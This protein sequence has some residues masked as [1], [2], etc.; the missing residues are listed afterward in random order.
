MTEPPAAPMQGSP[1]RRLTRSADSRVGGVAGGFAEYFEVDPTLARL[2]AVV[3]LLVS[4]GSV[5][6]AYVVLW[7]VLPSADG[8]AA[9]DQF[10]ARHEMPSGLSNPQWA[11]VDRNKWVIGAIVAVLIFS[12]VILDDW[13]FGSVS[14]GGAFLP[15]L[16]IGVGVLLMTRRGGPPAATTSADP[17]ARPPP[18][19]VASPSED[20]PPPPSFS[21]DGGAPLV[22][23]ERPTGGV[24]PPAPA[25]A[26]PKP[27]GV[28]TPVVLS[29][30][31]A[32]AG[33][34]LLLDQTQIIDASL[35]LGGAVWLFLIGA[36]LVVSA[37][38]GRAP[39]L[40]FIGVLVAIGTLAAGIVDPIIEHGS[41][42]RRIVVTDI[43]DLE[44]EYQLGAGSLTV[45]LS[46]LDLN[47][48]TRTVDVGLA[49][50][51]LRVY[52]P[53]EA[54]LVVNLENTIGDLAWRDFASGPEGTERFQNEAGFRNEFDVSVAGDPD[55]GTLII[56]IHGGIGAVVVS[57]VR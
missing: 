45:D 42:D 38:R 55:G 2:A 9:L 51:E 44:D 13:V 22:P 52:L 31:L 40:F 24:S 28:I 46:E 35:G 49:V 3:L 50:G 48:Q 21:S 43:A 17:S 5:L 57:R 47:G 19:P 10:A 56:H 36:G 23:Y 16:L 54:N 8:D 7:V 4:F 15:I 27:P 34:I 32:S 11:G 14:I 29:A 37:F 12:G 41:A 18:P 30:M 1:P 25:A 26:P 39:G 6:L 33:V 53:D 20:Q